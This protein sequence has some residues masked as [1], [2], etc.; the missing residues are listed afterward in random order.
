[1]SRISNTHTVSIAAPPATLLGQIAAAMPARSWVYMNG[2]TQ[3]GVVCTTPTGLKTHWWDNSGGSLFEWGNRMIWN[4][5]AGTIEGMGGGVQHTDPVY[6][7]RYKLATNSNDSEIIQNDDG[8]NHQFE[9]ITCNPFDGLNYLREYNNGA[10]NRWTSGSIIPYTTTAANPTGSNIIAPIEWWRGTITGGGAQGLLTH[11][12]SYGIVDFYNPLTNA[13][14]TGSAIPGGMP[15]S[16]NFVSAYSMTK[17]VLCFGGSNATPNA[18]WKVNSSRVCTRM[19]DAPVSL[20]LYDVSFIADPVT[21]KFLVHT[22][23]RQFWE[24]DPDGNSGMGSWTQLSNAPN[25]GSL[26]T[27]STNGYGSNGVGVACVQDLGV[28]VFISLNGAS[29][30]M[31][32]YK[33]G[34]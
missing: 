20:N 11:V 1:M 27:V 5:I 25:G 34:T 3:Y 14:L 31:H 22:K 10:I 23:D 24:L 28:V 19:T 16:Y 30:H 26:G 7:H 29:A 4:P 12:S 15:N 9:Q 8:G 21:G 18:L 33:H 17:N 32:V 13:W 6:L 2:T